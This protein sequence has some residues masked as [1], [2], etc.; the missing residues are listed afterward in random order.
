VS[1]KL[2]AVE[3]LVG[4]FNKYLAWNVEGSPN[5]GMYT[6]GDLVRAME[7]AKELEKEQMKDALTSQVTT[8]E[9]FRKVFEKQFEEYY[10]KKYK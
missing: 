3:W 5:A 7:R 6:D 4:E 9:K 10:N 8:D 2:T 1:K